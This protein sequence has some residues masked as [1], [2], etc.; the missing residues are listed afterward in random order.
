MKLRNAQMADASDAFFSLT[1]AMRHPL[2]RIAQLTEQF[3][4]FLS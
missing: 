3:Q 1:G 4:T 2:L